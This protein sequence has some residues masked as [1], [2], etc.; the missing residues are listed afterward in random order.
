MALVPDGR[1]LV[2]EQGGSLRVI[3]NG[4]LL[5]TPFVTI[6]VNSSGERGLLGVAVDPNF[7]S[8]QYIYVY[9][10]AT[11]PNIHNRISRFTANGDVA[12]G[13]SELAIF[14]LDPLSSATN[15][16]GGSLHFGQDGK[17]YAAAGD[18]GNGSNSQSLNNVLGKL[19]RMNSDGSI[20]TD[21]P[22]YNTAS[23]NN[24]AIWALGLRNPFTFAVQPG[25]SRKFI[26]DVGQA[27]YEEINDAISGANY[28]WPNSEGPT[29]TPGETTP[30]LYYGHGNGSATGCAITG[31]TF[32]NPSTAQFPA[33]YVG[34]YFY[35]DYCSAW[36]RN[37]DPSNNSSAAFATNITAPV[38]LFVDP[39]GSLFYL[40]R[41]SGSNTGVVYRIDY[42]ANQAPFIST[43]PVDVTVSVGQSA[44]FS[45]IAGG[46]APLSY[47]WQRNG[48]NISGATS[49][50]YTI[51]S[52]T[53]ND[54]GALFRCVVS[55]AYGTVTSNQALLTVSQ[56]Q[57]PTATIDLPVVG[58]HYNGG[59]TITYSG[60]GT[61]PEDGNEPAS[62]FT[63]EVV[64]H[65]DQ[66]THPFILPFSGTTG[67]TFVIP[68]TGETSPN[69][70]YRIHLTITD[71]AGATA[72]VYRDIIPNLA[73]VTVATNPSGLQLK[74]DA[75]PITSPYTFSGVVGIIRNLEA[76]SPQTQ[77]GTTYQYVSW[78]D[79]G[80]RIHDISTPSSNTTYTATYQIGSGGT[81][82]GL[83]ATYYD[84][85]DFTGTTVSRID[86]TVD[87]Q[88]GTGV[89]APGIGADTFSVR[90]TGKVQPLY[91]ENYTFYTVSDD[92]VRLW[93]NN[94]QIINNWTDHGST[95][96]ASTP[97][98]LQAG[99]LYDIKMEFY[100]NA[101]NAV[102]QLKW[103]SASQ[104]KAII[105]TSQL[106]SQVGGGGTWQ[107]QDIGNVGVPGSMTISGNTYTVQGS[108]ADI[109]GS[110]D[111]FQYAYQTLNGDGQVIARL[112]SLQ[113]TN[114]WAKAGVMIR[115]S[116]TA[117]SAH[118]SMFVTAS[119]GLHFQYRTTTN[120]S[121]SDV[122]GGTGGAPYWVKIARSQNT[123][124][125]Y[126]STDG[127][128]WTTVGTATI[129]MPTQVFIGLAVTSHNNSVLCS[130]VFDN[131]SLPGGGG[132]GLPAPWVKTDIGGVG[133]TGDST[134]SGGT[135]T[136]NGSGVDIWNGSDSFQFAYQPR[137]GDVTI[138]A[139][140][141]SVENTNSWAKAGV[142]IRE[143]LTSGS[144][145]AFM[146]LTPSN[147]LTFQRRTTTGGSSSATP[148][149]SATAPYWVKLIRSGS[150]FT[151]YKSSDGTNWTQV[152]SVTISMSSSI[153]VG[154][155]VSA[156]NNSTLCTGVFSNVSQ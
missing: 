120:G 146:A 21:N 16:N 91:S 66:H 147:G 150:T 15:H 83:S 132:G 109:W 67:G 22:F 4:V 5:T 75:Q 139:R 141:D 121:S 87:F 112:S 73:N 45:V 133:V 43:Q 145:H 63:W 20:P 74:L 134:Y 12:A 40:A 71:S 84:N 81:G 155:A 82:D 128:N 105:P 65:H 143:T 96:N 124:T 6:T 36:I 115:Q 142:M 2:C 103:S 49:P 116:L 34:H 117:N 130:A 11:S 80:T 118:A 51:P 131:V 93:V 125:A 127:T 48:T 88:W 10:T 14:D 92:G 60:T 42:T 104:S 30:L 90:W 57:L 154:L 64:F 97:I 77:G 28:G 153:Y 151:G 3:K 41:G 13:G 1:I 61:D 38:D 39:N 79:G 54:N 37:M 70:W 52:V 58:T 68:T 78:S 86:P 149:G 46:T 152:G 32:Y 122:S 140:V 98:T 59:Q 107:H 50:T 33:S 129:S 26:D 8:N 148:G 126:K 27:T 24:R 144:K 111:G 137:T 55:N 7:A 101:G 100:E 25:T 99:Q 29:S 110:Y 35:A 62:A 44:S 136:V 108:G 69:V 56:N 95:E 17:L 94:Q 113:N 102:A 18:N 119:N 114:S 85:K 47:Q 31:G 89:P 76:V 156:H 138:V 106:Y 23:G 72:T 19:L 53:I 123:L 9:Y 135:F